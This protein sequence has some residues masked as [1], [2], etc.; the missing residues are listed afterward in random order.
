MKKIVRLTESDL[1]RIVKQVINEN[2]NRASDDFRNQTRRVTMALDDLV[3]DMKK[4]D[5]RKIQDSKDLVQHHVR[6]LE[7]ILQEI[8]SKLK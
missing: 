5:T 3:N 1:T 4:G 6:R 8:K 2:I 7:S